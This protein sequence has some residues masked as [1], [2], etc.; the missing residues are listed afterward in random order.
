MSTELTECLFQE[1]IEQAVQKVFQTMMSRKIEPVFRENHGPINHPHWPADLE[2][3]IVIGSV[4]FTGDITGQVYLYLSEPL[5]RSIVKD[6]L[7]MSQEEANTSDRDVV[8]DV[9]GEFSNM[10]VGVF[11]NRIHDLGYPCKLTIPTVV[12]G[13]GISIQTTRGTCRRTYLFKV[14]NHNVVADLIFKES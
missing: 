11:K 6:M 13:A 4:G 9:I 14:E 10:T 3:V 12:W 7:G 2:G 8:S 1:C 5:A